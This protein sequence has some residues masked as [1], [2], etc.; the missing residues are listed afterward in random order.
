MK[1]L[2]YCVIFKVLESFVSD[3]EASSRLR[4]QTLMLAD[5]GPRIMSE[6]MNSV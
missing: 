6:Q 3:I 1:N 2:N 4:E 5:D